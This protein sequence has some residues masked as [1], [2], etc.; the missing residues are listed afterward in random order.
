MMK[1]LFNMSAIR[2]AVWLHPASLLRGVRVAAVSA[3]V[4]AVFPAQAQNAQG[5]EERLRTQLR[6]T[7]QQL[8]QLQSQQAQLNAAVKT[9]ES[10]RDAVTKERDALRS[11]LGLARQQTEQVAARQDAVYA[12][13]RSQ[14]AASNAQ[15]DK[16][17][18]AY[19]ELL[20]MA[21][22]SEA[23]RKTLLASH[24]ETQAQLQAC[25]QKND[26]LYAAG[27]EILNA[28]ESFSTGEIFSLRQPFSREARIAFETQ[29]QAYGDRLYDGKYDPRM[30]AAD[31][32]AEQPVSAETPPAGS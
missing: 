20:G 21:R 25:V 27:K 29:A 2:G 18:D 23:Q 13:A 6:A 5:M 32:T 9:A 10:Q 28:Y 14:V 8:Q 19:E 24:A 26:E 3:A 11:E 12:S 22:A 17:K 7:T 15:L 16:F 4:L 31:A 1:R 30:P